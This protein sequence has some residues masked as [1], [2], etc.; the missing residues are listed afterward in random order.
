[1][2]R[3]PQFSCSAETLNKE[4]WVCSDRPLNQSVRCHIS[5]MAVCKGLAYRAALPR[6]ARWRS[7]GCYSA[8][9]FDDRAVKAMT[10][11]YD[12][13][14]RAL[15]LVDRTDPCTEIIARKIVERAQTGERDPE[16]L[17]DLALKNIREH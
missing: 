3:S 9:A 6:S 5:V 10:T 14:L 4:T 11:A 7:T 8:R 17:S 12:A 1:M 16:R 15:G 2:W 13:A